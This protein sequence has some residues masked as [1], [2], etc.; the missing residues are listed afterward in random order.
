MAFEP[1]YATAEPTRE[2]LEAFKGASVVEFGTPWC[3]WCKAAQPLI[4]SVLVLH[5]RVQH[6]KVEDGKGR[7]LGRSFGVQ[8]WPTLVFLES[9]HEVSR[10]VRPAD[11]DAIER[12]L[13]SINKA[14]L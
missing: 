14:A 10:L 6:V 2:A 13:Q 11:A 9:G 4:A 12:A 7:R 5:P 8:L 1:T 3:G